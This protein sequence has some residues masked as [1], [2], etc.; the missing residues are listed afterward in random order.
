M[1]PALHECDAVRQAAATSAAKGKGSKTKKTTTTFKH[2]EPS[3]HDKLL[4]IVRELVRC[5]WLE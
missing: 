5:D 3:A 1:P 2:D 4:L